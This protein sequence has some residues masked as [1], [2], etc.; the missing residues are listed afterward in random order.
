MEA[1]KRLFAF[2]TQGTGGNDEARL[3]QLLEKTPGVEFLPFDYRQKVK[4]AWGIFL[5][6]FRDRP[7]LVVLEGTGLAGGIAVIFGR[8]LGRVPY[9][10][11]SGDAI[12]PFISSQIPLLWPFFLLFEKIL[13]HFSS[14]FI[15]WTPYLSGRA[16]TFGATRVMTAPGWAPT[17]LSENERVQA[18][19]ALRC[20][21][22]IPEDALVI[23]I[24]G[25]LSW[26]KRAG[27]C[28]GYELVRAFERITRQDAV[29]LIVGDGTG[30][31]HLEK[32]A[33]KYLGNKIILT[34]QVPRTKIP[35]LLAAMDI[36]SLPQ[37]VDAVGSFRYSTKLTEFMGAGLPIFMG[38]VPMAFD[39]PGNWFWRV[40][41]RAPWTDEYVEN[42]AAMID[43]LKP[44]E[45]QQKKGAVPRSIP[46]FEK[47]FQVSRV[48]EFIQSILKQTRQKVN[49]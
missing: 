35:E 24:V 2:A 34:G 39:L 5:K 49:R 8:F 28:Y 6:I 43:D 1:D 31:P 32:L 25:S 9:V 48:T 17:Y 22:R 13:T 16:I 46:E 20:E 12:A 41:G 19:A 40:P 45:I 11:S 15:G 33:G 7:Q 18:R 27:F 3:R 37:S 26:N 21:Y 10:V 42:L 36:A 4:S 47:D 44:E 23:G 14:G 30:R 29:L 38:E